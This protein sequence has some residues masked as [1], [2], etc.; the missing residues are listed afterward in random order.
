MTGGSLSDRQLLMAGRAISV[1]V[2]ELSIIVPIAFTAALIDNTGLL[3]A[4][5]PLTALL[6]PTVVAFI[7]FAARGH[8]E[9]RITLR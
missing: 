2:L 5:P 9:W 7:L 1:I 4:L 3:M 8:R 6:F